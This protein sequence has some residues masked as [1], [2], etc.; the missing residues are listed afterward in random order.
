VDSVSPPE[1]TPAPKDYEEPN[2]FDIWD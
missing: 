1:M 2:K